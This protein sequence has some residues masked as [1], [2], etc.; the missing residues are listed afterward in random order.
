VSLSFVLKTAWRDARPSWRRLVFTAASVV[1]GVAALVAVGSFGGNLQ[2]TLDDQA[3]GLL[4][5]DLEVSARSAPTPETEA[6]LAGLGGERARE[7]AFASMV[8]FPGKD[9]AADRSRLVTVR[10]LSG[11]YPFYGDFVTAPADARSALGA[12]DVV[13]LEETLLRQF[14]VAAGDT[15]RLGQK[16]FRIAGALRQVPGE[17]AAVA[18]LSPRVLV[19]EAAL[20]G[21][22]LLGPGAIVRYKTYFK[23]APG[24]DVEA[25]V[26]ANRE[27]LRSLRLGFD[28]VAERRE[29]LG[30]ALDNLTTFLGLTGFV[31]LFLG[32]IGVASSLHVYARSKRGTV[33]VLRCLGARGRT[34][35]AVF[36]WQAGAIGLLGSV[37]GAALGLAV[38]RFLPVLLADFLP[39][40]VAVTVS[41]A[42]A[43]RGVVIGLVLTVLFALLPLLAVRR[44]SPLGALR[45]AALDTGGAR[46]PWWFVAVGA[47]AAAV[48]GFAIWQSGDV[49][50]G[51]GFAGGL[52]IALGLLALLSRAVV[53]TARRVSPR[54]LPYVWRQGIANLHRP[55]NRTALLMLAL[56]LGTALLLTLALTRATLLDQLRGV[57][58]EGRPDLLFFDVQDDQVDG[59]RELL[60]AKG[61][62]VMAE[63]PI[64]T[65]R[66]QSLRGR[67][68]EA[69]LRAPDSTIPGWTLRREYRSTFRRELT[70][71]EKLVSG[72][73]IPEVGDPDGVVP[74]SV[75][76]GLAEDL[77]IG[78]GDELVFDVQGVPVRTRVASLREVE[79]RRMSPNFFVVFPAGV[80]EPAPKFHVLASR[81]ADADAS[82]GVQQAV[83]AAFPNVSVIDLSLVIATLDGIFGKAEL[84][85]RFMALFTLATG[86][87][88][89][90]GAVVAG[91][92]QRVREIV[93]LRTL[94]ASGRQLTTIQSIEYAVLGAL[95]ALTGAGLAVGANVALAVWVFNTE[96]SS[97]WLAVAV[98][99]PAVAALSLLTGALA[100]RGVVGHS[101]LAVLRQAGE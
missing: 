67:P 92:G 64:V 74:V 91:R 28:T 4:G 24:T 58:S 11:A 63:A 47:I 36:L 55:N 71:T 66:L 78:L 38:Q 72:E 60:A 86:L 97:P 32:A 83:V 96:P 70:G 40:D 87:V 30:D 7:T 52:A 14:G 57:G 61:A 26:E 41:W 84:V 20:E 44:V 98:A 22:G 18:L 62:P 10:A 100:G 75:E 8:V 9:G 42:E 15:I 85:V 68:V 12:D 94:G 29:E 99:V 3:R 79:W 21:T 17:S 23:F 39:V 34:A 37:V 46:D 101:P 51:A 16:T 25:L 59:V 35:F 50:Q 33:A 2:R 82:A 19:G 5:A 76:R 81:A 89:L 95:A 43:G 45:T 53:W 31:A 54:G 77:Q 69:L 13:I 49:R 27:R 88:V 65:M 73:W 6:L 80:L 1:L 56:G 90:G 48:A 93:L